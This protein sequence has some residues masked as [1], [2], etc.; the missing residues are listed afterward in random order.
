MKLKVKGTAPEEAKEAVSPKAKAI[1]LFNFGTPDT[2][3]DSLKAAKGAGCF[4]ALNPLFYAGER[5][6][7][8][9]ELGKGGVKVFE[10]PFISIAHADIRY[11]ERYKAQSFAVQALK[12]K[13]QNGG[14]PFGDACDAAK[15]R[16]RTLAKH[17]YEKEYFRLD[18]IQKKVKDSLRLEELRGK[19]RLQKGEEIEQERIM[20]EFRAAAAMRGFRERLRMKGRTE[21]D[22]YFEVMNKDGAECAKRLDPVFDSVIE[23]ANAMKVGADGGQA[24]QERMRDAADRI[25]AAEKA[26]D[27]AKNQMI[28]CAA[29]FRKGKPQVDLDDFQLVASFYSKIAAI[30][31]MAYRILQ[32]KGSV[33]GLNDSDRKWIAEFDKAVDSEKAAGIIAVEAMPYNLQL[34]ADFIDDL[35]GLGVGASFARV[36][37][38]APPLEF[39]LAQLYGANGRPKDGE[40]L[41]VAKVALRLRIFPGENLY[42]YET[43]KKCAEMMKGL[44]LTECEGFYNAGL[45]REEL[46]RALKYYPKFLEQNP[47]LGREQAL[48][49]CIDTVVFLAKVTRRAA[50]EELEGAIPISGELLDTAAGDWL[51]AKGVKA[52]TP[53]GSQY[54]LKKEDHDALRGALEKEF[55]LSFGDS[56]LKA[57]LIITEGKAE[58]EHLA[59]LQAMRELGMPFSEPLLGMPKEEF[60]AM[61]GEERAK[62]RAALE[63]D[64]ADFLSQRYDDPMLAYVRRFLL[65]GTGEFDKKRETEKIALRI[66]NS[67]SRKWSPRKRWDGAKARFEEEIRADA[68]R[69]DAVLGGFEKAKLLAGLYY[70]KLGAEAAGEQFVDAERRVMELAGK[71]GHVLLYVEMDAEALPFRAIAEKVKVPVLE[72]MKGKP[73]FEWEPFILSKTVGKVDFAVARNGKLALLRESQ[74]DDS[75]DAWLLRRLAEGKEVKAAVQLVEVPPPVKSEEQKPSEKEAQDARA[76]K[77]RLALLDAVNKM[78]VKRNELLAECMGK[79]LLEDGEEAAFKA[80]G[81]GAL[82]EFYRE[83]ELKKAKIDARRELRRDAQ[84]DLQKDAFSADA[85]VDEAAKARLLEAKLKKRG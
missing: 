25:L 40:E 82:G 67:F 58:E 49:D 31:M 28:A 76:A 66:V 43:E 3:A 7:Q 23:A 37:R 84:D 45:G 71:Y 62:R 54:F 68:G 46:W 69:A 85:V 79:R 81:L 1:I 38:G 10:D 15:T 11:K 53:D 34:Y 17:F 6:E 35:K 21:R 78:Q 16:A 72:E 44:T 26:M 24:E 41:L 80:M 5:L 50:R 57:L 2:F 27:A 48:T 74:V 39:Q 8:F 59:R 4:F 32:L 60:E 22:A 73:P 33:A 70:A 20:G 55:G 36:E 19:G 14:Q 63:D 12:A 18:V 47:G 77:L 9:A 51:L 13:E 83:G 64:F 30:E 56:A 65:A 75:E 52:L 61:M 42:P 29:G